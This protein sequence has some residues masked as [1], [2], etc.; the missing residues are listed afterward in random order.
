MLT[1]GS[2]PRSLFIRFAKDNL[3][4]KK[5]H[6]ISLGQG[7]SSVASS[8]IK[9][10]KA[11]GEWILL[12]NCHLCLSFMSKLDRICDELD[13]SQTNL[14]KKIF[15]FIKNKFYCKFSPLVDNQEYPIFSHRNP[16]K[17]FENYHPTTPWDRIK[18]T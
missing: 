3:M 11:S 4:E 1:P 12:E 5:I 8:K 17:S 6:V 14:Q 9:M 15:I 16:S 2:D 7:I 10:G 18:S 13:D